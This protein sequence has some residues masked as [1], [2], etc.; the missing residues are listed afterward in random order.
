MEF[1][2][3]GSQVCLQGLTKPSFSHMSLAQLKRSEQTTSISSLYHLS[4]VPVTN[5]SSPTIHTPPSSPM[6]ASLQTLL[7]D[8]SSIFAIPKGLPP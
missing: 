6:A 5:S 4:M 7:K 2:H 8:F 3:N 1:V